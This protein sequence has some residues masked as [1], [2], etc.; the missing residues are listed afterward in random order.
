MVEASKTYQSATSE[1]PS[2]AP[3]TPQHT[4]FN[5]RQCN[6]FMKLGLQG[7]SV[8]V[9]S[10]DSGV[11]GQDASGA[12]TVCLGP[13]N[14]VFNPGFPATCPYLTTV[15]GTVLPPGSLASKDQE[16]AVTRFPSGGGFR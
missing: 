12:A 11:A 13:D 8:F 15:G 5:P 7:V 2:H 10:G 16:I 6:E 1:G 9:S 14:K 4:D 3:S